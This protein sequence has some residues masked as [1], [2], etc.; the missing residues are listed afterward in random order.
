MSAHL[1]GILFPLR[2]NTQYAL[3]CAAETRKRCLDTDVIAGTILI[4]LS[5]EYD[6][7]QH[8]LLIGKLEAYDFENNALV[9]VYSSLTNR[10]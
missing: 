10:K 8:D 5:K 9:L 2:Y 4:D 1:N 6:C 7:I 3:F